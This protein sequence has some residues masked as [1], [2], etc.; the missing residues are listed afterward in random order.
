MSQ[1]HSKSHNEAI[2]VPKKQHDEGLH[3]D[4]IILS[5]LADYPPV[6]YVA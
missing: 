3:L 2:T 4:K 6:R 5:G 1:I